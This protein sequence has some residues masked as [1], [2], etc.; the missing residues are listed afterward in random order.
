M[1]W[2]L[3]SLLGCA[4]KYPTKPNQKARNE[5]H[6]LFENHIAAIGG[7]TQF[8]SKTNLLIKGRV[9]TMSSGS[10][11]FTT[12]KI[13][14]NQIWTTISN[15]SGE[16]AS[17]SWDGAHGWI[18]DRMLTPE[19][20]K[21]LKRA[22]NFYFPLDHSNEYQ[23]AYYI[24]ETNFGGRP[25]HVVLAQTT[26]EEWQELFFDKNSKLLLGYAR[27][28]KGASKHWYR[29]G[30]YTN[31]NGIKHPLSIEE[32]QGNMHKV[33]LIESIEWN[34]PNEE[35]PFPKLKEATP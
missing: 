20:S 5:L 35:L 30:H 28:H 32:K 14:P 23:H 24:E 17:R 34:V 19:E 9:R 16:T 25:A 21:D 12:I 31:I 4:P 2:L 8:K 6:Q 27:W 11:S 1:T 3:L 13:A 15:T 33:I 26:S 18:G 10:V 22:A 7:R 29:F